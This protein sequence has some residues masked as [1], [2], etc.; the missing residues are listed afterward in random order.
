MSPPGYAEF[1]K[2][3]LALVMVAPLNV[4]S[5]TVRYG[6]V[7]DGATVTASLALSGLAPPPVMASGGVIVTASGVCGGSAPKLSAV[8]VYVPSAPAM[9]S[10]WSLAASAVDPLG[11]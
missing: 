1:T 10:T 3:A 6:V 5:A 8:T 2:L 9:V 7:V 4:A 11:S